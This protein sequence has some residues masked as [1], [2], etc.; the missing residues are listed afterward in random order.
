MP[1][2]KNR[3]FIFFTLALILYACMLGRYLDRV[4][5]RHYCDFRVY[6]HTAQKFLLGQ[7]I[8]YRDKEAVT[9]FKYSPFFA[10]ILA[11]LGNLPIKPAAAIFFT[12][13]FIF[14]FLLFFWIKK[15]CVT[16]SLSKRQAVLLYLLTVWA[17][18]RFILLVWDSGQVNIIMCALLAFSLYL[19]LRG[20]VV[21]AAAL[22]AGS[23]FI[24]YLPAI[25]IP[26]FLLRRK[27]KAVFLIFLFVLLLIFL[28]SA[29]LGTQKNLSYLSS[30]L[31]SIIGTSLDQASYIDYKNQSFYSMVIRF[32]QDSSSSANFLSLSFQQSLF[33]SYALA[34]FLYLLALLPGKEEDHRIDYALFFVLLPL[35]NP[36]AWM[37]NFVALIFP[38]FLLIYYLVKC[39]GR[40]VFVFACAV[41]AFALCNLFGKDVFGK[42]W[43]YLSEV[44]SFTAIGALLLFAALLKLKFLGSKKVFAI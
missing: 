8:Y 6:H 16:D 5:Q 11:P 22:F 31:P 9:P 10:F 12:I 33:L 36:N 13:N 34:F 35:L 32:T 23:I 2:L 43:Q 3:K 19:F 29:Y 28:P 18:F 15:I 21:G 40:D 1:I 25:F 20:K 4:P 41:L 24:K 37:I 7:D 14:T 42:E 17:T 26:Y 39:A 30:W 27:L 38:F 44:Y